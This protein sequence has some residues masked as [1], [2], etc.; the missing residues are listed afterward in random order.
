[1]GGE[2]AMSAL[3]DLTAK[4][5]DFAVRKEAVIALMGLDGEKASKPAKAL[6]VPA[7]ATRVS[8]SLLRLGLDKP[9]ESK[10]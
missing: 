5:K 1:V 3:K 9:M 7:A 2:D 8:R 6:P 4:E 10:Q